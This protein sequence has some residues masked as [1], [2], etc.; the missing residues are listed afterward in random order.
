MFSWSEALPGAG[1][2]SHDIQKLQPGTWLNDE[3]INFYI[4]M[5]LK[6]SALAAEKRTEGS[7]A[8]KR[9]QANA[10]DGNDEARL[11]DLK[12]RSEV[13]KIWNGVW[14]VHV[15]NSFF[16]EKLSKQGYSIPNLRPELWWQ[17]RSDL[18][19]TTA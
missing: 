18:S 12:L 11:A 8:Q 10:Y 6:R 1:V 3:V 19:Q 16:F 5:I 4:V 2:T 7:A 17:V 14:D 13:K 15:F 9:I